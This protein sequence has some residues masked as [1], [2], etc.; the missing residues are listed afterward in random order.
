[1]ADDE[2]TPPA[3]D[4]EKGEEKTSPA[5]EGAGQDEV[6]TPE[7]PYQLPEK[8]KGKTPDQIAKAY[9]DLEKKLGEQSTTVK[10]AKKIQEQTDTLLRAI[11]ANPDLYRQVE[12]GIKEYTEGKQLPDTR[13]KKPSDLK[14]GG[15]EAPEQEVPDDLSD[16]KRAEEN[17]VLDEF[18]TKFGYKNLSDKERK[19]AYA[20]VAM[21]IAELV[22]PAGKRPIREILSSIP[23]SKL[24]KYL[25][26]AH[27]IANKGQLVESAK[28]SA[29]L[30]QRS[31]EEASIG[32]FAASSGKSKVG[33]PLS[34]RE[35]EIAQKLGVSEDEYAKR[36]GDIEKEAK[37]FG[38]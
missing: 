19:D 14:K 15:E 6:K 26:N 25:E 29:L 13:L 35:R 2:K 11:W 16:L 22:D 9:V 31:N 3:Q 36:K 1:M 34:N 21:S 5:S 12:T 8:F 27:F 32:S 7:A 33:V 10:E 23:I 17:R 24:P 37:R 30:D 20:R 4:A 18:F 38:E 28:R